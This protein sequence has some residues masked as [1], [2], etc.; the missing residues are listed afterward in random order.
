MKFYMIREV[1]GG[2]LPQGQSNY[3]SAEPTTIAPPRLFTE[4]RSA[5]ISLSIWRKGEQ[6]KYRHSSYNA[7]TGDH[8]YD[9]EIET[10]PKPE[11]LKM[12]MVVEPVQLAPWQP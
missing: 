6:R 3:T 7:Y 12:N 11:R 10:I 9:E 4:E 5:K 2:W 8:D 1:N